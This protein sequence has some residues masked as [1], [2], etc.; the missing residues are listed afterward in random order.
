LNT[1]TEKDTV[2]LY[3]DNQG[4]SL[5]AG[6]SIAEA[7]KR[8]KAKV[9]THAITIAASSAALIFTNGHEKHCAPTGHLMYHTASYLTIG[10]TQQHEQQCLYIKE[11]VR[12]IMAET[13]AV[14][15]INDTEEQD[16]NRKGS[17]IFIPGSVVRQRL[18][19]DRAYVVPK[20]G[21]DGV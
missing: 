13:K 12:K 20:G 7:F 10:K 11:L 6:I 15:L 9:I 5:F 17:D 1:A 14:G 3:I 19:E 8:T 18:N 2:V 4:G 16:I 21:S